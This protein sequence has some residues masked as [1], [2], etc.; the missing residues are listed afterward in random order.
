[1]SREF[2][3]LATDRPHVPLLLE[4]VEIPDGW[5]PQAETQVGGTQLFDENSRMLVVIRDP[6]LV[7]VPGEAERLLGVS[8]PTPVW[9]VEMR[10][11]AGSALAA[12]TASRCANV[13]AELYNGTI[14]TATIS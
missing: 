2:I 13:M 1:M 4:R 9:W 5:V 7:E 8:A 12:E 11:A 10:A 14:W 6:F 3:V